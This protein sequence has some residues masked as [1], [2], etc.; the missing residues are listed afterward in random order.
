[1]SVEPIEA[2]AAWLG[3]DA[4][5]EAAGVAA[6]FIFGGELPRDMA[7]RM[8]RECVVVSEAGG[9]GFA[10]LSLDNQRVDVRSYGTTARRAKEVAIAVHRSLKSLQRATVGDTFLHSAV[11][12][13]GYIGLRE[14]GVD[15]PL[16]L[17]SYAVLYDE[18][19]VT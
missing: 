16:V 14:P 9:L 12:S 2:V 5:V 7:S 11:A 1:V 3:D 15:W 19:E 6:E 10:T 17:R 8:P 4:G 18:R 13:G